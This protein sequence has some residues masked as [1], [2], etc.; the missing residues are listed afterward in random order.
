MP[1]IAAMA[2]AP[3]GE[4][5]TVAPCECDLQGGTG[6]ESCVGFPRGDGR[7]GWAERSLTQPFD[8]GAAALMAWPLAVCRAC[9]GSEV[10]RF[11]PRA[12]TGGASSDPDCVKS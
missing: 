1:C 2:L 9:K 3:L 8:A 11:M 10:C 7:G 5:A 4:A 6:V 12:E